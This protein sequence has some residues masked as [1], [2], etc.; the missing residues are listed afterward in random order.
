[1]SDG[2]TLIQ[3]SIPVFYRP[4]MTADSRFFAPGT[5]KPAACVE[6]WTAHGLPISICSFDPATIEDLCLAHDRQYVEGVLEG[7][8]RNGFGGME[9][10]VAASLPYTT[11]AMMAAAEEAVLNGGVACAPVSGFHHAHYDA[12]S[13][14]CTFNGLVV[15]ARH[16]QI[17]GYAHR[18]GILDLDQHYG[19]G[20][21]EILQRLSLKKIRHVTPGME[22]RQA[23][24]AARFLRELPALVRSFESCQVLLYQAGADPHVNDPLGGWMTT[25]QLAERDRIV[26]ETAKSLGL[27]VAWNL[28]GGYQRDE[29]GGIGP[30]LAIHRATMQACAAVYSTVGDR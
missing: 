1:M 5:F 27:P 18:I 3:R 14:F 26:F 2:S 25:E 7:R 6:N 9:L 20:T 23:R 22:T 12:S 11:G 19:D 10:D 24:E 28:A 30:V 15:T 4:E 17:Q 29:S 16:L 13:G 8:V 21:D